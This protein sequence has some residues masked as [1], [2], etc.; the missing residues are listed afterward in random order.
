MIFSDPIDPKAFPSYEE[1]QK[2]L[3]LSREFDERVGAVGEITCTVKLEEE[4]HQRMEEMGFTFHDDDGPCERTLCQ[5]HEECLWASFFSW[6]EECNDEFFG[7]L[8]AEADLLMS[9]EV[10]EQCLSGEGCDALPAKWHRLET[11]E[12]A[13]I[14]WFLDVY[15]A[16]FFEASGDLPFKELHR[17]HREVDDW[18][19]HVY[20]TALQYSRGRPWP[21]RIRGKQCIADASRKTDILTQNNAQDLLTA[22]K[23]FSAEKF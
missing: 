11:K 14:V 20:F 12:H 16:V 1:Y 5:K 19:R 2:A 10:Q 6:Q 17:L 15:S 18:M 22:F 13:A 23:A 4:E 9:K 8:L 3:K 7:G 21:D